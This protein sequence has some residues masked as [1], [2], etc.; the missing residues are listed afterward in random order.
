MNKLIKWIKHHNDV[1]VEFS[2]PSEGYIQIKMKLKDN[3]KKCVSHKYVE[4][5]DSNIKETDI[6][7]NMRSTLIGGNQ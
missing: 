1:I 6:L 2:V 4:M 7:N 3:F 5:A